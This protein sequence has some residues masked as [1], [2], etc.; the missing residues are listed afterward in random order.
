MMKWSFSRLEVGLESNHELYES[1]VYSSSWSFRLISSPILF[2]LFRV[3]DTSLWLETVQNNF[4]T[5]IMWENLMIVYRMDRC[6]SLVTAAVSPFKVPF[7]GSIPI[8]WASWNSLLLMKFLPRVAVTLVMTEVLS[9]SIVWYLG[10]GRSPM[11]LKIV[12]QRA[13]AA[14][15][16]RILLGSCSGWSKMRLYQLISLGLKW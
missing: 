8:N 10:S 7:W 3:K 9:L 1:A 4:Y 2:F 15:G 13:K 14:Y 6:F 5:C 12:I 11:N 16:K